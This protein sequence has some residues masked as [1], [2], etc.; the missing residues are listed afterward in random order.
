MLTLLPN[1]APS[2]WEEGKAGSPANREQVSLLRTLC[3]F[4]GAKARIEGHAQC[5]PREK[6]D[7]R[8]SAEH[9][10]AAHG[11]DRGLCVLVLLA[12]E[13]DAK[14]RNIPSP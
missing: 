10:R 3:E 6:G 14:Q 8:K 12:D 11:P 9:A 13:G 1:G 7:E 2:N 5:F 4:G